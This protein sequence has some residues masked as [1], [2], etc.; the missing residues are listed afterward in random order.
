MISSALRESLAQ[1]PVDVGAFVSLW[2]GQEALLASLPSKY[3]EALETVLQRLESS[4]AFSEES[5]S[6]SQRDL[7]DALG[8][9]LDR[10]EKV[11]A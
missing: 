5:C 8:A 4:A 6:F 1:P 10:A 7:L 9:W 2:R 11:L 3:S